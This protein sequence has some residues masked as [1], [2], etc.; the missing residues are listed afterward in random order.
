MIGNKKRFTK[1]QNQLRLLNTKMERMKF[2][3]YIY[4]IEHP[5]RLLWANFIN[6]LVRGLGGA[7]GFTIVSAIVILILQWIVKQNLP[8]ISDFIADILNAVNS[9]CN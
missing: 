6:G 2:L 3:D 9:K 5:Y 1:I 4:F 7:V 8:Y